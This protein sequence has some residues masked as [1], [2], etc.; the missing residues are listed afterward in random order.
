MNTEKEQLP[1]ER[2][3]KD[4]LMQPFQLRQRLKNVALSG[5]ADQVAET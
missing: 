2:V 3:S 4:P 5:S 1:E